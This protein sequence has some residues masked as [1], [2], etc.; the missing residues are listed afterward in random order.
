MPNKTMTR[1]EENRNAARDGEYKSPP[2]PEANDYARRDES[3]PVGPMIETRES[4][5]SHEEP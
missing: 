4:T 3:E 1:S 5:A 2:Q